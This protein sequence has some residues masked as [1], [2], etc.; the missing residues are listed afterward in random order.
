GG[1]VLMAGAEEVV[2]IM[3]EAE[4]ITTEAMIDDIRKVIYLNRQRQQANRAIQ[5]QEVGASRCS[6]TVR[7][8]QT[9]L[10]RSRCRIC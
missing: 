2:V 7:K 3:T 1:G 10:N 4:V 5:R 8:S 9:T 6:R